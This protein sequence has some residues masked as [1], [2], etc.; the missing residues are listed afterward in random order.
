VVAVKEVTT[1]ATVAIV[2]AEAVVKDLS[3][4]SINQSVENE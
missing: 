3:K 1:A 4:V 2:V